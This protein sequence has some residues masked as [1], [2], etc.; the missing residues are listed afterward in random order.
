MQPAASEDVEGA[1]GDKQKLRTLAGKLLNR[2][3]SKM[4]G[5]GRFSTGSL[6]R[7]AFGG[8]QLSR[9][10]ERRSQSKSG[11]LAGE[12][13]DEEASVRSDSN[14]GDD[15][16]GALCCSSN[17]GM[18]A[19]CGRHAVG[20]QTC[21]QPLDSV[22][23]F[24]DY[25]NCTAG[26][27]ADMGAGENGAS[28]ENLGAE[29]HY[30]G[31]GSLAS[32]EQACMQQCMQARRQQ[33]R[34]GLP[35][36]MAGSCLCASYSYQGAFGTA[37]AVAP[38]KPVKGRDLPC[39]HT[40]P[41][42]AD[43]DSDDEEEGDSLT[44]DV[45]QHAYLQQQQQLP[46]SDMLHGSGSMGSMPLDPA[47]RSTS[48]RGGGGS[49]SWLRGRTGSASGLGDGG[50]LEEGSSVFSLG[51][52]GVDAVSTVRGTLAVHCI[53]NWWHNC[54]G[55]KLVAQLPGSTS[56]PFVSEC[57]Q[58]DGLPV[59]VT[60]QG[61]FVTG[62]LNDFDLKGESGT[63]C[64]NLTS[65]RLLPGCTVGGWCWLQCGC[66]LHQQEHPGPYAASQLCT[67]CVP[68]PCAPCSIGQADVTAD[69]FV[70]FVFQYD[71]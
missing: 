29:V 63:K 71:K 51:D 67:V 45:L 56:P 43:D 21:M 70:R 9:D 33:S 8:H 40:P 7:L 12:C 25:A 60:K 23:L 10:A 15:M 14:A 38:L 4:A 65:V 53:T 50:G 3:S 64:P 32:G 42:L 69:V 36:C 24:G 39:M 2:K 58:T 66:V 62:R 13:I 68:N 11:G 37:R 6:D 5:A 22:R 35:G 28:S 55:M 61:V 26:A 44:Q 30:E 57:M 16:S 52:M 49:S 20:G 59:G 47:A 18:C 31:D 48:S 54:V 19:S 46:P 27:S 17:S 1:G 41:L 34:V